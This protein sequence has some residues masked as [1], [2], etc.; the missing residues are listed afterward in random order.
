MHI[1][2]KPGGLTPTTCE[3]RVGESLQYIMLS[4]LALA[5]GHVIRNRPLVVQPAPG[6]LSE[7]MFVKRIHETL[8]LGSKQIYWVG[9]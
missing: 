8:E 5:C 1:L 6:L 4:Y 2:D 9:L 7:A 3:C